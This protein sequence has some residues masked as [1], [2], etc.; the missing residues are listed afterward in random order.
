MTDAFLISPQGETARVPLERAQDLSAVG[1]VPASQDQVQNLK[2]DE[3]AGTA[4][5]QIT[6][7]GEG[8]GDALTLGGFSQ[9]QVAMGAD[10]EG[11]A[12]RERVNPVAH[13]AGT[14]AGVIAPLIAT[15]GGSAAAEGGTLGLGSAAKLTA[16]ALISDVGGAAA[17]G[18]EALLPEATTFAGKAGVSAAK[19]IAQGSAEGGLYGVGHVVHE[20]ALGDP[21]LTAQSALNE[22]GM[23]ALMGGGAGGVLGGAQTAIP[24]L[25][26]K[27]K[28]SIAGAFRKGEDALGAYYG[29]AE[30]VTGT[31]PDVASLM[32]EHRV[33]I[34][35]LDKM[36]PG[37]ADE[38]ANATPQMAKWTIDN[39]ARLA[40]ME[41]A[42]PGTSRQLARTSPETA[43]YL[44]ANWQK[45]ITDPQQR[46]GI[47]QNL[48]KGMQDVVD[49]TNAL[50]KRVNTDLAPKEAEALLA[51][52]TGETTQ[53]A[54]AKLTDEI[55]G[56]IQKMR[57]EPELFSQ[58]YARQLEAI[59]DGLVRDVE[60]SANPVKAF[61]RM[62]TLRQS[63]DEAIPY[64]KD[65]GALGLSERNALKV[66]KDLRGSVKG[67]LTDEAVFGQ[68]AARQSALDDAQ[69]EW[70]SLM[71]R[72]GDFNSKFMRKSVGANGVSYDLKPTKLNTWLNQMADARGQD[73]A[74]TWGRAMDA[75]RKVTDEAEASYKAAPVGQF[76]RTALDKLVN[77]SA[78]LTAEARQAATVTQVKNQLNPGMSWGS[79]PIAGPGA[80]FMSKAA[81]MFL[82]GSVTS[83]IKGTVQLA[84][85]VPRGVAALTALEKIG[86]HVAKQIDSGV[87]ALVS[88]VRAGAPLATAAASR[89][90]HS[91]EESIARI[92]QLANN[93]AMAQEHL[94]GLTADIHEHAPNSAMAMQATSARA[95]S[96]LASKVP[97][98]AK[99]GPLGAKVKPSSQQQ[100]A[101]DRYY[102]AV[103][104]P[105]SILQ[106]AANG[107]LTSMDVEA[108][109]TV[110]PALFQSMQTAAMTKV[111]DKKGDVPYR[112]RL[113]LSMLFG[114]DMDGTMKPESIQANQL[115][116]QM[117]S[118]K[119]PMDQTGPG[120]TGK[121]TQGGLSKLKTASRSMLPGQ[122]A[123]A[124]RGEM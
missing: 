48:A 77:R 117:P 70:L 86:G 5:E 112:S 54:Y 88:G 85:S 108:V 63:L 103:D 39:G 2:L 78:E 46:V 91:A 57:A 19:G 80:D 52:H 118:Q 41:K 20:D 15:M 79:M 95:I 50:L 37:I 89:L 31:A 120:A 90:G 9:L 72:G 97:P 24:S 27:A 12:R 25:V 3:E 83:T 47:A 56:A 61:Q 81:H 53:L 62:R 69:R 8:L 11:I 17:R 42:F 93:P 44:L 74:D 7:F 13:G 22:I 122:G 10:P 32:M 60:G 26:G 123:E 49:S 101:F 96:F 92:Q 45:I 102:N 121:S 84:T 119:G 87:K 115:A 51:G 66:M 107:T 40:E 58:G 34:D 59:R 113:M 71:K 76:D 75:A 16:P 4:P 36:S 68:A 73:F 100:W 6:A 116:Y 104:K 30:K 65:M 21:N 1:W 114:A 110:F 109:R 124:R 33:V 82:P 106:H 99:L 98:S 111:I 43:D 64:T 18:V 38:I 14:A 23:S 55:H 67:T 35:G 105:T 29:A 28:E 94:V